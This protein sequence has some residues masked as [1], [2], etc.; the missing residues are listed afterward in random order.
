M[1]RYSPFV[2]TVASLFFTL[3]QTKHCQ[4]A[5]TVSEAGV[6]AVSLSSGF[7]FAYRV[8]AIWAGNKI[9]TGIVSVLYLMMTAC[10]VSS[11]HRFPNLY[12]VFL[13]NRT[14]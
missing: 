9:V 12:A 14:T 7:I 1:L 11:C 13:P 3:L 4:T 10:W 2:V 6:V 8:I 5:V